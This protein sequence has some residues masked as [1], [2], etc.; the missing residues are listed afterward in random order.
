M[1]TNALSTQ[2]P[3]AAPSALYFNPHVAALPKYNAG[4]GADA[5]RAASGLDTIAR[6]ASNENP[7]GCSPAVLKALVDGS[8]EPW[9]YSDPGCR[10]LR[11]ALAEHLKVDADCI[12]VGNG[13]EE[14]IAAASRAFLH[15]GA[16][17]LTVT[18]CFGLHEIEPMAVGAR[19]TKIPM[20]ASCEFDVDGITAALARA[21]QLFFLPSPWNPVGTA[22]DNDGLARVI[23]ATAE[24]TLFVLDEAYFEF[25]APTIPD[26]LEALRFSGRPYIVLRTFSKAYGLAGLRVGYAVCSDANIARMLS[27]AKTPFNVNA[28]A[29]A[30]AIAALADQAWMQD[31]VARINAERERVAAAL[32]AM[33]LLV[34]P[35]QGNFLFFDSKLPST[36][37]SGELLKK[38]VVVKPWMEAP[39]Q[40]FVR[41][42]IGSPEENDQFLQALAEI[43]KLA[44]KV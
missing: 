11:Q 34:A 28:V 37:V 17:A 13:S 21:P 35:A 27:A 31:S 12:V 39:Y 36:Q 20:T 19:V 23:D 42:S 25:T 2:E 33:G 4:L 43:L 32:R 44:P 40:T 18:P 38:G 3:G 15:D 16:E 1:E 7:H 30:A 9:R 22:L 10:L 6:L 14:M 29:Q 26:G 41:A 24:S 8:V 5:A